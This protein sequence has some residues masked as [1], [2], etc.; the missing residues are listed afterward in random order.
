[1]PK[2]ISIAHIARLNRE[3]LYNICNIVIIVKKPANIKS[4]TISFTRERETVNVNTGP[5][6][7]ILE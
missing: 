4:A 1:M 6:A 5:V 2:Q 7:F 3:F